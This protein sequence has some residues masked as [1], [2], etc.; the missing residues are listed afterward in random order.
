MTS[1]Y[2]PKEL[3]DYVDEH[4]GR[5]FLAQLIR[6]EMAVPAPQPDP[7]T[8]RMPGDYLGDPRFR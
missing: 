5:D 1:F 4:G 6:K 2:L 8:I 7:R 3:S